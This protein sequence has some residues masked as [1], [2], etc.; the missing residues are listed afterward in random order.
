MLAPVSKKYHRHGRFSRSFPTAPATEGKAMKNM[1]GLAVMAMIASTL[2]HGASADPVN[3]RGVTV[4]MQE[5]GD[6]RVVPL[7]KMIATTMFRGIGV[8]IDWRR[9]IYACPTD[10]IVISLSDGTPA[11]LLPGALAYAKPYEG[12]HIVVFYDRIVESYRSVRVAPLLGHVLVH[13]ITHILEGIARHSKSGVMTALWTGNDHA[14]MACE[15]MRFDREDVELIHAGLEARARR[16]MVAGA[17]PKTF[18]ME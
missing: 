12:T 10:G 6:L 8:K 4:C 16:A 1:T 3:D 14:Q 9:G 5:G 17:A 7:A 18:A 13:E 15:H 11:T 2:M